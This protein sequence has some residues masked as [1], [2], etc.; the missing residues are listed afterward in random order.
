MEPAP[1]ADLSADAHNA[2]VRT[3][4]R[5]T[6]LLDMQEE[7]QAE[8]QALRGEV[9][10]TR[11]GIEHQLLE[12]PSQL[13]SQLYNKFMVD[14]FRW[15]KSAAEQLIPLRAVLKRL[16]SEESPAPRAH[17]LPALGRPHAGPGSNGAACTIA[18]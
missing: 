5:E 10:A 16:A 12:E 18:L 3:H 1:P 2:L 14:Q 15:Y 11:A 8:I 7:Q 6:V 17:G 13:N 4:L 9:A